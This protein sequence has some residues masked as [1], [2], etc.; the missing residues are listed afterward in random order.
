MKNPKCLL[1]KTQ[2]AERLCFTL[3]PLLW[4]SKIASAATS[5][6]RSKKNTDATIPTTY[7]DVRLKTKL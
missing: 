6:P 7:V 5:N 4:F 3:T 1:C 2:T